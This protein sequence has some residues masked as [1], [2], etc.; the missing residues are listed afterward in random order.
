LAVRRRRR[1]ISP[2]ALITGR[3]QPTF[4][5]QAA[6]TRATPATYRSHRR[7]AHHQSSSHKLVHTR[8]VVSQRPVFNTLAICRP[9]LLLLLLLLLLSSLV[10]R[11]QLFIAH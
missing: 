1:Q 11:R 3:R 10:S 4:V 6:Q 2:A 7:P 8:H 5:N 9:L